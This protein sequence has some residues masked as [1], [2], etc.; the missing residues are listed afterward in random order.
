MVGSCFGLIRR[1]IFMRARPLSTY[2]CPLFPTWEFCNANSLNRSWIEPCSGKVLALQTW[3]VLGYYMSTLP[4][5]K[6]RKMST[7]H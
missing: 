7:S 4:S 3:T 1:A 2:T 5:L 6:C